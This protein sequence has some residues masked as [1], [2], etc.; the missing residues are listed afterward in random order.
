MAVVLFAVMIGATWMMSRTADRMVGDKHRA[1]ETIVDTGQVPAKWSR[2]F[3]ARAARL[4]ARGDFEGVLEIQ[5]EAKLSYLH[6]LDQLTE[7]AQET[8]LVEDEETRTFLL[9]QLALARQ[10]WER[11]GA[12]EF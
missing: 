11:R 10:V 1:L 5:R 2:H 3:R 9:D 8:P 12:D 4:Q 6:R 7:Y